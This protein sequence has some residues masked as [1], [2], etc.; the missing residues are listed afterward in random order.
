M[1]DEETVSKAEQLHAQ[2]FNC[3]ESVLKALAEA[4]EK[5]PGEDA[6][7]MASGFGAGMGKSGCACGA[8]AGAVMAIGL[9]YGRTNA[10]EQREPS[11]SRA[12]KA[13]DEF[14]KKFKAT[15]CKA[16]R[17]AEFGTAEQK[18]RCAEIV[19]ETTKI[20]LKIL[21]E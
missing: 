14:K 19:K 4:L 5:N 16:I 9:K 10:S 8:L 7:K 13:H 21:K 11:Y 15:C 20:A 6:F 2:G 12:N 17:K 3:C 18:K 1:Q